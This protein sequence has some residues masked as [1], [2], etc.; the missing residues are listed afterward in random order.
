MPKYL[1]WDFDNPKHRQRRRRPSPPLEGEVLGPEPEVDR[2]PRIH[3]VEVVHHHQRHHGPT[4]QRLVIIAAFAVLALIL[5]RSPGA[6]ILLAVIIPSW[7][8]LAAGVTVAV[9][10]IA[11]IRNHRAARPF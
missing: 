10:V 11:H 8:W 9:L 6:L 4:P 2:T 7:F 3:H 5:V 1:E